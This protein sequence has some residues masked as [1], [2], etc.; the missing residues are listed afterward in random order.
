MQSENNTLSHALLDMWLVIHAAI[1]VTPW[2]KIGPWSV[3]TTMG[4]FCN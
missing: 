3:P 2:Q 1:E 4:L